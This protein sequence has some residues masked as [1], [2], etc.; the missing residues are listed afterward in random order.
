MDRKFGLIAENI[1]LNEAIYD[2]FAFLNEIEQKRF[3]KKFREQPHSEIQIM[4]TF[5]ELLVGAYL[6]M[7]GFVVENDHEI[8]NKTPDWSILDS[9]NDVVAIVEIINHHIDNK[10]NDYILEQLK[11]GKK[12]VAYFPNGNDPRKNRL[13]QHIQDKAS[14]YKDLVAQINV[15]Y[16]VAV[17]IDFISVIDVQETKEILMSGDESL[18]RLYP[19][20]SGVL[21][22]EEANCGSYGFS[23]IENPYALHRISIPSGYLLKK[24]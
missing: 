14:K 23:F 22:F 5:H 8:C 18:F 3:V 15:P 7:N 13:Y 6:C 11:A 19:Y 20:L 9:S 24:K 10:T 12:V 17:F 2:C 16:V 1:R 4:H 21:Q